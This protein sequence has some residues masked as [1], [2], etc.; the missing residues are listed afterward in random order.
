[1]EWWGLVDVSLS[2]NIMVNAMDGSGLE[3]MVWV[4]LIMS[5]LC[6]YWDLPA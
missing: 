1:M 6:T 2:W 4:I 5:K 3:M